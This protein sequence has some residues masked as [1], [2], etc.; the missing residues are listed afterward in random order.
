MLTRQGFAALFA[1]I[2]ALFVG[3]VFGVI[4][5]YVI[6]A[7]FLVAT[8]G[9]FLFVQA[10]RPKIE[11]TRWIHP[12][13]LV[14]G[15]TGRVDLHLNHRGSVRSTPFELAE[16]V[17][18][19]GA[20]DHVAR[21]AVGSLTAGATS[22]AGYQLPTSVRGIIELGPLQIESR[23]PLG[24]ARRRAIVAGL[25]SVIVAPRTS[26]LEVPQLGQ[27]TLGRLLLIQAR[28]L[29]PGEFHS[30][31]EYVQGDEP[32]SI[33]WKASARSEDLVVKEHTVEGLR[34]CT[35]VLDADR[36][37]YRDD[38][39][40]ERAITAAAS[41]VHSADFAGLTTRFVT[42]GGVDLRGPEVSTNTLRFLARIELNSEPMG[43][44]E[45]DPGEGLGL[46]M[47]VTGTPQGVGL[48]AAQS[49]IDPTLTALTVTTDEPNRS[50]VGVS[51]R[52]EQEFLASWRALVGIGRLDLARRADDSS[53]V[54]RTDLT[55]TGRAE[56][57]PA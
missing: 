13:V 36:K 18:R 34:R 27:G 52:S 3:R 7:G 15:D 16:T 19:A 37:S 49:M 24:I 45:R 22:T 32:R 5:L 57:Q 41:L 2:A 48:R 54:D 55:A 39:G 9:S 29:G 46:L 40:F 28:R 17:S 56:P 47:I 21:L 14:A 42:G 20:P 31:R 35:V 44:L 50:P 6:G 8:V 53:L 43:T 25:D 4:E 33:H 30:L 26:L 51:A 11:A 1:G 38:A 10:R 12:S 23:D